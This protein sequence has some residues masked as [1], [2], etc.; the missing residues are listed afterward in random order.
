MFIEKRYIKRIENIFAGLSVP[1]RLVDAQGYAVV[2]EEGDRADM[3]SSVLPP[4]H[5]AHGR[6]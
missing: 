4:G 1:I 5:H 2:P 3:P 6:Q